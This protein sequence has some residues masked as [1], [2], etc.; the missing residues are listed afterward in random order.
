MVI[1]IKKTSIVRQ[2]A[3]FTLIEIL[4]VVTIIGIMLA[5]IVPRAHRATID[6]KYNLIRQSATEV[7]SYALEWAEKGIQSQNS[8]VSTATIQNYLASL[9]AAGFGD[10]NGDYDGVDE[11]HGE[12]IAGGSGTGGNESNWN[13]QIGQVKGVRHRSNTA[14]TTNDDPPVAVEALMPSSDIP[15]N[16]FNGVSFFA[17]PNDPVTAGNAVTGALA[18]VGFRQSNGFVVFSLCFQGTDS[19]GN[20][21]DPTGSAGIFYAGQGAGDSVVALRNGVVIAEER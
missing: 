8:Q 13:M 21:N 9:A 11:N 6:A 14:T 4:L 5:V 12:W 18:C 2:D 16:P 7:A 1:N 17:T 20:A 19:N 15:I 10:G 3:G